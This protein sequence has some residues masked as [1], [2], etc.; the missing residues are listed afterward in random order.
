MRW[1]T[2]PAV[3]ERR[4]R[5]NRPH[6]F[7]C[8]HRPAPQLCL[9]KSRGESRPLRSPAFQIPSGN[10]SPDRQ[11][12]RSSPH[13]RGSHERRLE[14][15]HRERNLS[16]HRYW[17]SRVPAI[18]WH[19]YPLRQK[20]RLGPRG[21]RWYRA[22]RAEFPVVRNPAG[23]RQR[24]APDPPGR[25]QKPHRGHLVLRQQ[26]RPRSLPSP[27]G[28]FRRAADRHGCPKPGQPP[29]P[30]LVQSNRAPSFV[31]R[32]FVLRNEALYGGRGA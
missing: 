21:E 23:F 29:A 31:L 8:R 24:R 9:S 17:R 22:V 1:S 10:V 25:K 32:A 27:D 11:P 5:A 13:D 15:V 2:A 19:G 28:Q 7:R 12:A 30:Q 14:R 20:A 6:R 16:T 26:A 3:R 18:R 4:R